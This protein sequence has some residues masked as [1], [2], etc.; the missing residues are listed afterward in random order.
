[1]RYKVIAFVIVTLALAFDLGEAQ[2]RSKSARI[3]VLRVDAANSP[4]ATE[5]VRDLKEGLRNLGYLEGRNI[6]FEIRWADNKLDQLPVLA[7]ELVQLKPDIIIS[8]GPQAIRAAK[9]AT[10]RI[11]IVMGR[12]DDA[13]E[14]GLVMSLARPGGTRGEDH[15]KPQHQLLQNSRGSELVF[16]GCRTS[17]AVESK[18]T[19]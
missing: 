18:S 19:I 2:Q 12:M 17:R 15:R 5:A 1:M 11:P 9:D 13:V 7:S 8:G 14:H 4:A 10:S 16:P 3:G 6:S